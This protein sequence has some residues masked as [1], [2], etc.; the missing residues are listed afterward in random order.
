MH[1]IL[2]YKTDRPFDW[3][4]DKNDQAWSK[5]DKDEKKKNAGGASKLDGKSFYGKITEDVM[6]HCHTKFTT[7]GKK[8]A[9][10]TLPF[11]RD[12]EEISNTYKVQERK[13]RRRYHDLT[14]AA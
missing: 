2:P 7:D 13:K 12:L 5:T 14:S 4:P 6:R 3:F 10:L 11:L 8:V 1:E 9:A